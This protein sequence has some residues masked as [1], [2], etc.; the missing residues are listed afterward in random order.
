METKIKGVKKGTKRGPYKPRN[1]NTDETNINKINNEETAVNERIEPATIEQTEIKNSDPLQDYTT[2]EPDLSK[3]IASNE[4]TIKQSEPTKQPEP[5][6]TK[7][8]FTQT[9]GEDKLNS[10]FSEYQQTAEDKPNENTP[11]PTSNGLQTDPKMKMLING[12]MLLALCDVV[13]PY[14]IKFLF[15]LFDPRAKKVNA[16]DLKL[17]PEQRQ[18]LMNS[19]D[20]VAQ[21]VFEKANPMTVFVICLGLFYGSNFNDA[22]QR[23]KIDKKEK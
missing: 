7:V 4:N 12:Y 9:S 21:Y 17:E 10:F 15:G 6:P 1:K 8:N 13:F 14:G 5:E 16:G 22:M 18:A 20:A 11:Q 23:I 3:P 2:N 19:A